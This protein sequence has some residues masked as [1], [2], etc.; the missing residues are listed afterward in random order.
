MNVQEFLTKYFSGE[1]DFSNT[2]LR[3]IKLDGSHLNLTPFI[4]LGGIC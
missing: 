1:R 4:P 3:G 2:D